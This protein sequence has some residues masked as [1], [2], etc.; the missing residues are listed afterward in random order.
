MTALDEALGRRAGLL[1]GRAGRRDVVDA[2]LVALAVDGDTI[3]TS[4]VGD[5][6]PLAQAAGLHVDLLA[7]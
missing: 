2:A 1:L 6:E 3:L 4:D 7:V 5:L